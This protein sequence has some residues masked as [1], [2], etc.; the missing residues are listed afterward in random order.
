[1]GQIGIEKQQV[2]HQVDNVTAGEV[3]S[4]FLT[5]RFRETAY[6][7]LKDIAAIHGTYLVRTEV[8]FWAVELLNGQV[9]GIALHHTFDDV[10]KV[11]FRKNVLHVRGRNRPR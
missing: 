3:R 5:E 10:I 9:Q 2:G 8:T 11:E 4:G 1:M 7:V 6:Q